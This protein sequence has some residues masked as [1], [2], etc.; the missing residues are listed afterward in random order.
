MIY[1]RKHIE[2]VEACID[3]EAQ[4]YKLWQKVTAYRN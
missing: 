1:Y 2:Y 4:T 3:F